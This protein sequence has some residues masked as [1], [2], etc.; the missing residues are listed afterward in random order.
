MSVQPGFY[1]SPSTYVHY[2][3][4]PGSAGSSTRY[5]LRPSSDGSDIAA[6][7]VISYASPTQYS[8]PGSATSYASSTGP[9]AP[10]AY[11]PSD[12]LSA[13]S[14]P[15]SAAPT[16]SYMYAAVS[17]DVHSSYQHGINVGYPTTPVSSWREW[18]GHMATNIPS[19][20]QPQEYINSATAL[21]QLGARQGNEDNTAI[22]AGTDLSGV[23]QGGTEWPHM[24][25]DANQP[26]G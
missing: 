13:G 18:T 21:M 10:T 5:H 17:P 25:F 22:G 3:E 15:V 4:P 20:P 8:F 26:G 9:Y 6:Q 7:T 23:D 19:Q 2:G 1:K 11:T 14:Q 16:N 24:I 12:P